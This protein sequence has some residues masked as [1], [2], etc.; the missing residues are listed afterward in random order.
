M[1]GFMKNTERG[2]NMKLAIFKFIISILCLIT[3][4]TYA[5]AQNL[6][7]KTVLLIGDSMA[8][9]VN[10]WLQAKVKAAGGKY[11]QAY[12]RGTR[13]EYW[14]N[15]RIS[16][17]SRALNQCKPDIVF[18]LL[19]AN[20]LDDSK[21]ALKLDWKA[22]ISIDTVLVNKELYWVGPPSWKKST[23][24]EDLI[25]RRMITAFFDSRGIEFKRQPDGK[26]LTM[27]EY[28]RWTNLFWNWFKE[29]T[30]E[31]EPKTE[32]PKMTGVD[33]KFVPMFSLIVQA[34]RMP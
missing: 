10:P 4:S 1:N 7:G 15:Q 23:G 24:I 34:R 14:H 18:I 27:K 21:A 5:S 16:R 31:E 25:K 20:H 19:G 32:K 9:G 29:N 12:K 2:D 26:H 8:E 33:I 6:K 11:C 22:I 3:I 30:W 17:L 13:L 28:G